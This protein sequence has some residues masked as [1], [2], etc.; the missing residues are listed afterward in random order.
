[1]EQERLVKSISEMFNK[2]SK[3]IEVLWGIGNGQPVRIITNMTVLLKMLK[4]HDLAVYC[5]YDHD[6][7]NLVSTSKGMG[8]LVFY[9][10]I[11]VN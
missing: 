6:T 7:G 2:G 9:Y 3:S 5:M 4:N 10:D 1:M 11:E 8:D